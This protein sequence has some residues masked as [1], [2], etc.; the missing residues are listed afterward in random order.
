MSTRIVGSV[1]SGQSV[2]CHSAACWLATT[3]LVSGQWSLSL[4]GAGISGFINLHLFTPT[5]TD[6]RNNTCPTIV[7]QTGILIGQGIA[8][9][10]DMPLHRWQFNEAYHGGWCCHLANASE[11]ATATAS[12]PFRPL[13]VVVQPR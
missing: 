3:S 6:C 7:D 2:D 4:T 5:P 13:P 11:T 1:N 10:N 12:L 9:R 8:R